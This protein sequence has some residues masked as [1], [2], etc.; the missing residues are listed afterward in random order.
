MKN[1]IRKNVSLEELL[2]GLAEEASE[3]AQAA[4]KYRRALYQTNPTPV[5]A[6][7]AYE[8]LCEEIADTLLYVDVLGMNSAY[9]KQTKDQKMT[10]WA[11][12]LGVIDDGK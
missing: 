10:R 7:D 5:K 11:A 12:R 4:L 9:I 2:V 1:T 3:L 8:R 6:D